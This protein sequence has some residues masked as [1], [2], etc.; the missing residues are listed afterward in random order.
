MMKGLGCCSVVE[1]LPSICE[2]LGLIPSTEKKTKQKTMKRNERV[3]E[4]QAPSIG[5]NPQL[6]KEANF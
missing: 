2:A 4:F 5:M 3:L 6:R 1:Y